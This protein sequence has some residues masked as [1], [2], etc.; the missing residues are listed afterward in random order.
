MFY[1][2]GLVCCAEYFLTDCSSGASSF[3]WERTEEKVM[4]FSRVAAVAARSMVARRALSSALPRSAASQLPRSA[5]SC[6][7]S[8]LFKV[9]S[10]NFGIL[11]KPYE[12][13]EG[14]AKKKQDDMFTQQMAD[15]LEHKKLTLR[16]YRDSIK[17]SVE[18]EAS[19]WKTMV[20]GVKKSDEWIEMSTQ[21]A[22]LDSLTGPMLRNPKL[23]NGTVKKKIAEQIGQPVEKINEWLRSYEQLEVMHGWLQRLKAQGKPLPKTQQQAVEMMMKDPTGISPKSMMRKQ[24]RR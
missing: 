17:K 19:G 16:I 15:L 1:L 11:D 24:R 6:T 3:G 8:S 23:V 4:M 22:F 18:K 20:P 13:L 12:F 7:R 9:Q 21:I 5:F 14:R 2:L 10:R